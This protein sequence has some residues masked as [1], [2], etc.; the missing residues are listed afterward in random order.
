MKEIR[1]I[2][3]FVLRVKNADS[4]G[5]EAIVSEIVGPEDRYHQKER[6]A[7]LVRLARQCMLDRHIRPSEDENSIRP[8]QRW[9]RNQLM[10]ADPEASFAFILSTVGDGNNEAG[11]KVSMLFMLAVEYINFCG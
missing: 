3:D 6:I 11:Q 5:I 7:E 10:G 8:S 4:E 1:E 2:G 9:T